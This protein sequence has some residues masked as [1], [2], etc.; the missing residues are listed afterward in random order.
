M[1]AHYIQNLDFSGRLEE[2]LSLALALH[3]V[4]VSVH[5]FGLVRVLRP[6]QW[7]FFP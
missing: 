6:I 5:L 3:H 7:P 4:L 2:V 1:T